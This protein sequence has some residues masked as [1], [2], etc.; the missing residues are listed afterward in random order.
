MN[1]FSPEKG[2]ISR[3]KAHSVYTRSNHKKEREM[4]DE[5]NEGLEYDKPSWEF[6]NVKGFGKG[7]LKPRIVKE[8]YFDVKSDDK[9]FPKKKETPIYKQKKPFYMKNGVK[10]FHEY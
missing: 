8:K 2:I 3:M 9:P 5:E 10:H 6:K 4:E 7:K 1:E